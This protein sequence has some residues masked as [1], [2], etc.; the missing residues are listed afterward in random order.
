MDRHN[1][2]QSSIYELEEYRLDIQEE[3]LREEGWQVERLFGVRDAAEEPWLELK[4]EFETNQQV[5]KFIR[6]FRKQLAARADTKLGWQASLDQPNAVLELNYLGAQTPE[7]FEFM[8]CL[9]DSNKSTLRHYLG[10]ISLLYQRL[11]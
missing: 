3:R 11:H 6:K 9:A 4:R 2:P 1:H 10:R 8:D 7:M 5:V